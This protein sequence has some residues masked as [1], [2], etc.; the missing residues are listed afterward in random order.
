MPSGLYETLR[1]FN[2]VFALLPEHQARLSQSC[3]ALGWK[4]PSI[5]S[6]VGIFKGKQD[7]RVR[8]AVDSAGL[9]SL[10]TEKLEPW[11][12]S[13]LAGEVWRVKPVLLNRE[14]PELKSTDRADL[15]AERA[16]ALEEGFGEILLMDEHG[17]LSEGG[18]SNLWL[19]KDEVL[20]VPDR[21][22]LSGIMRGLILKAAEALGVKV[23]TRAV[24]VSEL[25]N[26]DAVFLSNAIR[27]IIPTGPVHPLMQRLDT[28]CSDFIKQRIHE[29]N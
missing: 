24:N 8:F 11:S 14:S 6:W 23:E 9:V 3:E 19:V 1:S 18:I 5:L 21:G 17:F 25:A 13:L 28:W 29:A 10:K 26:F 22:A 7:L 4:T 16:K 27:G 12:G 20:I 2:G 15:D